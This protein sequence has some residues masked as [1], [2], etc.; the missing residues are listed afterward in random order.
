[1]EGRVWRIVMGLLAGFE[2]Y[3]QLGRYADRDILI[4][5]LWAVLHDRPMCWACCAENWPA[6]ERLPRLP[7]PSTVSRR[8]RTPRMSAQRESLHRAALERLEIEP[9]A[10]IDGKSMIVSDW[11]KDP[12]AKNGRGT[13]GMARGYKLHAVVSPSNVIEAFEVQPLNVN[14]RMPAK[15]LLRQLP[16]VVRRVVADGN[17]DG[18]S[19]HAAL[20][21]S[22]V[23][24]Y[25][26]IMNH[27]VGPR[28]H[29][30]R[31]RLLRVMDTPAGQ[32]L[33]KLRDDVERAFALLCNVGFGL[34]G[35]PNWIRRLGRV[36]LWVSGKILLHN[37]YLILKRLR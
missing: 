24:L 31:R 36:S 14:E 35:L 5:W 8:I 37:A 9:H 29:P 10:V 13:R 2:K 11:S 27:Y 25:T 32:R 18:S 30:R 6:K 19:V 3:P 4:V 16:R 26:P 15:R 12:D 23:L 22:G 20:E 1:M 28:T 7:H 34:K 21:G 17:Y 33:L